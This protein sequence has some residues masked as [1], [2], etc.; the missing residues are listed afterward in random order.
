MTKMYRTVTI[1]I[2]CASDLHI[3]GTDLDCSLML[4]LPVKTAQ[5]VS[6]FSS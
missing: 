2:V 4:L 6:N 5:Y 3:L 1:D